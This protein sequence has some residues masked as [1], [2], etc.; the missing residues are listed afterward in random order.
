MESAARSSMDRVRPVAGADPEFTKYPD[1]MIDV[2][3]LGRT[4]SC[5]VLSVAFAAFGEVEG[6]G[7]SVKVTLE[8]EEQGDRT[9]DWETVVWWM[10]QSEEAR[11]VF[12]AP[13]VPVA[14]GLSKLVEF[15]TDRTAGVGAA[16]AW[17]NG[18]DFDNAIVADLFAW[19]NRRT[20]ASFL[21]PW[22]FRNVRCF[23]TLKGVHRARYEQACGQVPRRGLHDAEADARWQAEIA[24]RILCGIEA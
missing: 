5:K 8:L 12:S 9:V 3:T 21:L 10:K 22:D 20:G 15:V 13:R 2:E 19:F 17:G 14:V 6:V 1:Y 11:A 4:P 18:S 7:P 24:V 16:R 23:R